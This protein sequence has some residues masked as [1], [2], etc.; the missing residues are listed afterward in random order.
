MCFNL[1]ESLTSPSEVYIPLR[2]VT[3]PK[4]GTIRPEDE[5][6]EGLVDIFTFGSYDITIG[7]RRSH[8][9]NTV[10][11]AFFFRDLP[12]DRPFLMLTSFIPDFS[13]IYFSYQAKNKT[14][15]CTINVAGLSK[16][17]NNYG[18]Y[19]SYWIDIPKSPIKLC[20]TTDLKEAIQIAEEIMGSQIIDRT[21]D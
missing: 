6:T 2:Q 8:V 12:F 3:G 1:E 10:E 9:P 18:V 15:S 16:I 19:G 17:P 4:R 20:E 7:N 13:P 14:I 21:H 11:R 5:T